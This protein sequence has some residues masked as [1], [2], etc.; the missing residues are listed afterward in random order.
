M[1]YSYIHWCIN[2]LDLLEMKEEKWDIEEVRKIKGK[3]MLSQFICT[4]YFANC[5]QASEPMSEEVLNVCTETYG[6]CL[7]VHRSQTS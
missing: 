3:I 7:I 2:G 1:M 6:E 5:K 4:R